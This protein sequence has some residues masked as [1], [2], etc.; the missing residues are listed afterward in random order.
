MWILWVFRLTGKAS[1]KQMPVSTKPV[2]AI[3]RS[4]NPTSASRHPVHPDPAD[5]RHTASRSKLGKPVLCG[6]TVPCP[7]SLRLAAAARPVLAVIHASAQ[8]GGKKKKKKKKTNNSHTISAMPSSTAS[9][10]MPRSLVPVIHVH[11][12]A[13][14]SPIRG[15]STPGFAQTGIEKCIS[16]FVSLRCQADTCDTPTANSVLHLR[17]ADR[18]SVTTSPRR[19]LAFQSRLSCF[20]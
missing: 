15:P 6:G 2:R 19:C 4:E 14:L 7:V 11:D 10:R 16:F 20:F 12:A 8:P 17:G 13:A 9:S 3:S 5:A 1:S 18:D